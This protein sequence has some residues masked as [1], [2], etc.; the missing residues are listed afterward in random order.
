MFRR[1]DMPTVRVT[2]LST[3]ADEDDVRNLF[4]RFGPISRVNVVRDRETNES[5][6][7][8]FV[9]FESKKHA[10]LAAEKMNG[11]GELCEGVAGVNFWLIALDRIFRLRQSY[12]FSTGPR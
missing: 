8:A 7:F 9:A 5:K 2:S 6:G 3:E 11:H 1:E 12:S 10:E 4:S